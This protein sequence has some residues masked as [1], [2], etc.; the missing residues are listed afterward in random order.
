MTDPVKAFSDH[1]RDGR[2]IHLALLTASTKAE[3][4]Q[5]VRQENEWTRGLIEE[6][7]PLM[8]DGV[9]AVLEYIHRIDARERAGSGATLDISSTSE[10]IEAVEAGYF[11][12]AHAW[13][14]LTMDVRLTRMLDILKSGKRPKANSG[15]KPVDDDAILD[16]VRQRLAGQKRRNKSAALREALNALA[17]TLEVKEY[18]KAFE[19][20]YKKI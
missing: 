4:D 9:L 12:E 17:S 15:R 20:I 7:A 19:R 8:G 5:A 10:T 18:D 11:S 13:A 3:S 1:Y 2:P 6:I 14:A 16:D